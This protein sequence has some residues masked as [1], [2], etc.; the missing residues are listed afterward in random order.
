M[1]SLEEWQRA[2][3]SGIHER[4]LWRTSDVGQRLPM[5]AVISM[6]VGLPP[7]QPAHMRPP[8]TWTSAT[9]SRMSRWRSGSV[10]S[11]LRKR[12]SSGRSGFEWQRK[13]LSPRTSSTLRSSMSSARSAARCI[14]PES[15]PAFAAAKNSCCACVGSAL[16][17]ARAFSSRTG[18]P[19]SA[20]SYIFRKSAGQTASATWPEGAAEAVAGGA[21][22]SSARAGGARSAANA[23]TEATTAPDAFA[24]RKIAIAARATRAIP[25]ETSH[26]RCAKPFSAA[27]RRTAIVKSNAECFHFRRRRTT[28]AIPIP[29]IQSAAVRAIVFARTGSAVGSL[30]F[31]TVTP[32]SHALSV[33]NPRKRMPATPR[34]VK[35][36]LGLP[37]AALRS[38]SGTKNAIPMR[39]VARRRQAWGPSIPRKCAGNSLSIW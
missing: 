9:T 2:Q 27:C 3:N 34:S 23:R 4:S 21:A 30:P 14:P 17:R 28:I 36:G 5:S 6:S 10:F 15:V 18:T 29:R 35:S 37:F 19:F 16:K 13:Q 24:R 7:W 31:G 12:I 38:R 26:E 1:N 8:R 11:R 20:A 25:P 32:R 33:R 22:F 39:T